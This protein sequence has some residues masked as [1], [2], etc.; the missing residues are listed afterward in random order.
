[1]E[2]DQLQALQSQIDSGELDPRTMNAEQQ[3]ALQE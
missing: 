1:M 3:S 2:Q